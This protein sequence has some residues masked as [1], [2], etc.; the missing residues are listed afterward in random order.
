MRLISCLTVALFSLVMLLSANGAADQ[1]VQ[2]KGQLA[3]IADD[4]KSL[5][6]SS[7]GKLLTINVSKDTKVF[8][9]GKAGKLA[10][11]KKNDQLECICTKTP[12]VDTYNALEIDRKK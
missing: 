5:K 3:S 4:A 10:D 9:D 1:K 2:V 7:G 11:L 6:V 8:I 12:T